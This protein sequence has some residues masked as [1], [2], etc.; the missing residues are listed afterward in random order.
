MWMYDRQG[1]G[2]DE[3]LRPSKLIG[4]GRIYKYS[5]NIHCYFLLT[6]TISYNIEM[7][8]FKQI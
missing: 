2:L 7:F 1:T 6:Y 4:L 3:Y 8:E 5:S